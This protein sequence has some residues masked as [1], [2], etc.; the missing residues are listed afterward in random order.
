MPGLWSAA[1]QEERQTLVR[2]LLERVLVEVVNGTEQVKSLA[3]GMVAIERGISWFGRL[4]ASTG[5]DI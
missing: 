4:P 1:T 2:S 3:T 5:S